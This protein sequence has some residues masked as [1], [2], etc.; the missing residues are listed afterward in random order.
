MHEYAHI[1]HV[2]HACALHSPQFPGLDATLLIA[3]K[4]SGEAAPL[5]VGVAMVQ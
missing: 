1:I 2:E 3:V 4:D 5:H